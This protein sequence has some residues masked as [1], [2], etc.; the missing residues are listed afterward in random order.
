LRAEL[1][2]AGTKG[3]NQLMRFSVEPIELT[4]QAVVTKEA[5]GRIGWNIFGV[6][7]K[8][9]AAQ[10]QTVT[11]KLSPLWKRI[12]GTFSRDFLIASQ[13]WPEDTIGPTTI[14]PTTT[15]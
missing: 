13:G 11:L 7:G 2:E 8:Y 6:G 3:A 9:E 5:D 14:G 1:T 4:V 10:T 15:D 12:D